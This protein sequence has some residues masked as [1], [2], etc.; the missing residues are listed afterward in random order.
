MRDHPRRRPVS[1]L[2]RAGAS[3]GMDLSSHLNLK[4]AIWLKETKEVERSE[5]FTE[6]SMLTLQVNRSSIRCSSFFVS[7][8]FFRPFNCQIKDF[9]RREENHNR[10][11]EK[12]PHHCIPTARRSI[13][14]LTDKRNTK[15]C[16]K[17]IRTSTYLIGNAVRYEWSIP[18]SNRHLP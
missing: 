4:T 18:R 15:F 5:G 6:T 7:F 1:L 9:Q 16:E 17:S 14:Y 12:P 11:T 3:L 8:R 2:N 13:G 10:R